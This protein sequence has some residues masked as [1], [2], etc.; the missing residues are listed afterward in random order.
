MTR[1]VMA[2]SAVVMVLAGLACTF[3]PQELLAHIGASA[4]PPVAVQVAGALYLGFAMINWMAK[5]SLIGGIYNRP[6]AV[7]NLLHF[8]S[9]AI[10]L[11]KAQAWIAAVVYAIFAIAFAK[12]VFTSPPASR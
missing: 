1:I 2:A 5:D 4:F 11:L 9:A 8:A 12:I 7:G 6:V 3:A 10:A